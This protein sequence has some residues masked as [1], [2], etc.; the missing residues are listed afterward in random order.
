MNKRERWT[1]IDVNE[2]L[3][4]AVKKFAKENGYTTAKALDILVAQALEVAPPSEQ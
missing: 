2:A 3:I 1:I 4:E